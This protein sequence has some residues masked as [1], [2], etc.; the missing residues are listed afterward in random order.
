MKL[1]TRSHISQL[2]KDNKLVLI[3]T[4]NQGITFLDEVRI[5]LRLGEEITEVLAP[6]CLNDT[7]TPRTQKQKTTSA[8][9]IP[10]HLYL[11]PSSERFSLPNNVMGVISTRS[12]YARL[13][14]ELAKS[15]VYVAPGFG[16][17]EPT[18]LVFEIT[19]PLEVSGISTNICYGF[20]L[21]IEIDDHLEHGSVSYNSRF[22]FDR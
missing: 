2:V 6:V 19:V 12:K 18:P 20:L 4:D 8:L 11:C 1:L 3:S 14:F 15:S 13:G 22:P 7:A 16:S 10:G 5:G 21:L 17:K 9:L